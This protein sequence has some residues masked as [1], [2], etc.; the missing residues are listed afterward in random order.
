MYDTINIFKCKDWGQVTALN[1]LAEIKE[2][3]SERTGVYYTGYLENLRVTS[4]EFGTSIKGSINK[5][6]H[7]DNFHSMTRTDTQH[8]FEKIQDELQILLTDAK[9]T[10]IDIGKNFIVS[11]PVRS[12][13]RLLEDTRYYNRL[14]QPDSVYFQNAKR[15][16]IFY[17]KVKEGKKHSQLIPNEWEAKN[18]IRYELR[19][20]K[21]V[22]EQLKSGSVNV[23]QLYQPQ[24]YKMLIDNWMTEFK[25]LRKMKELRPIENNM[26]ASDFK[27]FIFAEYINQVGINEVLLKAEACKEFLTNTKTLQR[28][29]KDIRNPKFLTEQN[30]LIQELEDM[31]LQTQMY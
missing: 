23:S 28:I 15:Q 8:G 1:C 11:N 2:S 18:V 7:G 19:Y 24:F 22:Q 26:T 31:I 29:K 30:H 27:D 17:D 10:R 14:E 20:L 12:Y 4:G 13:L 21:R 3:R 16:L 25:D 9:A 5:Y 6:F